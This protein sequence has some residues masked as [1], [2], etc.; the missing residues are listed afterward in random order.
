[1]SRRVVL[2]RTGGPD[3]LRVEQFTPERPAAGQA[4]VAHTVI[5]VNFIDTYHRSG[6]YPLPALPHGLGV[7]AVGVI[8]ELQGGPPE[9]S[10][11]QRVVCVSGA[12]GAYATH[13]VVDA[14]R[15]V[16]LPDDLSDETAAAA[17][18]KGMTVEYLVFRLHAVQPGDFV[19]WHGAAGGLGL[20]ACQWLR[21]L[22]ARVIGTAGGAAKVEEARRHGCE[23]PVDYTTE[24]FVEVVRQVTGGAGVSVVYDGV[25]KATFDASLDALCPRGLYVG[26]GNASGKPSPFD[27]TRLSQKGSLFLTR[28]TLGDYTRSR[29]ELL[30]SANRVFDALRSGVLRVH[31]GQRFALEEARALHEAL[32]ARRTIG[33]SLLLP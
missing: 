23:F 27:I 31:V 13:R 5:G 4:L 12:P 17:T 22:G 1:M 29:E 14:D 28:P 15:L 2:E 30:M 6:L 9:L 8:E 32:E 26:V 18:L 7:E 16:P 3:V 24:D 21:H 25:G 10:R 20:L 19:L 11:G 33:S